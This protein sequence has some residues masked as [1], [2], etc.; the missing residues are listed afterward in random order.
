M[1]PLKMVNE[2]IKTCKEQMS[3]DG[4]NIAIH[5]LRKARTSLI[6]QLL[7]ACGEFLLTGQTLSYMR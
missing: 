6:G 4:L 2:P 3:D 5:D 1:K 7:H